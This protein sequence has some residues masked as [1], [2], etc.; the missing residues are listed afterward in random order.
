MLAGAVLG[1]LALG[2][3]GA[4]VFEQERQIAGLRRD[5]DALRAASP[6]PDRVPAL[7]G[8]ARVPAPSPVLTSVPPRAPGAQPTPSA[9][10]PSTA[11][12]RAPVSADEVAR[13]ESAMLSLLESDRPVLRDKLRSVVQE[14]QETIEHEQREQR[15]ERWIARTESRLAELGGNAALTAQQRQAILDILLGSRDQI[16]DVF[17]S[18]ATSDDYAK[19]RET[20]KSLRTEADTRVHALLNEPQFQAYKEAMAEDE[21]WP[22]GSQRPPPEPGAGGPQR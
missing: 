19:A 22:F 20:V 2:A 6:D 3:L 13:V 11:Q 18:A 8:A 9:P 10:A 15:R 4:R 21:R 12:P 5:L 16:M 17:G 1:V 7:P 14:Q